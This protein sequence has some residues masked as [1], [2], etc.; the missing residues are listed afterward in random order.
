M[1]GGRRNLRDVSEC[2]L[3]FG[4]CRLGVGEGHDVVNRFGGCSIFS[5]LPSSQIPIAFLF[6]SEERMY[7]PN[8]S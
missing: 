5:Y 8:L 6:V 1:C 4:W 3:V 7:I 2:S